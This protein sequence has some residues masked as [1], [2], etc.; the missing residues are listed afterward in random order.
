[1]LK[2]VLLT[3]LLVAA[4]HAQQTYSHTIHRSDGSTVTYRTTCSGRYNRHCSTTVREQG[5]KKARSSHVY[6]G[7][8]LPDKKFCKNMRKS[9]GDN[10]ERFAFPIDNNLTYCITDLALQVRIRAANLEEIRNGREGKTMNPLY[11][12]PN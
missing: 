2:V 12:P 3:L 6:T 7:S 11:H 8:P 4:T 10:L 5:P 9:Y 1:M